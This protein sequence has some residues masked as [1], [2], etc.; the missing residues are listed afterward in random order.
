MVS[1]ITDFIDPDERDALR[2]MVEAPFAV[3][4]NVNWALASDPVVDDE[5]LR[6]RCAAT[7]LPMLIVH[8]S[9]DP[10]PLD[11]PS[12]VASWIP[13]ATLQ[14]LQGASH[15]PWVEQPE[16]VRSTLKTFLRRSMALSDRTARDAPGLDH[17]I[18]YHYVI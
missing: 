10:R 15:L 5:T 11:G 12:E 1:W 18:I 14:V 9:E 8:G 3:N 6:E 7:R 2:A 13:T 17:L 16:L 4:F